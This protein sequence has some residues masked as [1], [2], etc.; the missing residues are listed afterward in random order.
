[1]ARVETWQK[2]ATAAEMTALEAAFYNALNGGQATGFFEH[3]FLPVKIPTADGM[4]DE[5]EWVNIG[6][7]Y[8]EA[9]RVYDRFY[10]WNYL[11]E[12]LKKYETDVFDWITA[13]ANLG[14]TI[15]AV[16]E[17][18]K[19]KY[20][21]LIEL[22]GYEYNPLWNVD[23]TEI[24]TS[25]ENQGVTDEKTSFAVDRI[26][27]AN[28]Q[29]VQQV[30]RNTY[31]GTEHPAETVTTTA[32]NAM[33]D[34]EPTKNFTR[35]RADPTKNTTEREYTHHN[36]KNGES[37]YTVSAEDTAFG[38]AATGGDHYHTDKRVRRGNIGVTATQ[39]LIEMQRKVVATSIMTEFFKDINEQILI[40]VYDI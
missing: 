37:D 25:L 27:Y 18:N 24:Y 22:Q 14:E 9:A 38:Q 2:T 11:A 5:S 36:A 20:L 8:K 15:R 7:D 13:P 12:P 10:G 33:S 30:N 39:T 35:S 29:T 3:I 16:I 19:G 21:K 6:F 1:M 34:G 23:G 17:A 31:E 26:D 40:G 28:T 4:P 32:E